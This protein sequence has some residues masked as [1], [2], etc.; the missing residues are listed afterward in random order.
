MTTD[1]TWQRVKTLF[2]QALE[3]PAAQRNAWLQHACDSQPELFA[4]VMALLDARERGPTLLQQD[5]MALLQ[6]V[7]PED[8]SDPDD[9]GTQLGVYRLV[10]LLGTGGM[11]RVYLAERA[12]GQ[13]QQRVALKLIRSE[14]VT[15]DLDKR[16]QR[17]RDT[18]ARLTHPNIAQLH[19]G[20]MDR[21]GAS[22]FTLEYV[23]GEPITDWCDTRHVDLRGRV[24]L[25]LKVCDAVAY[26][27]RNLVVHRDLKPSNIL[28]TPEG[29]PKLLD[30]GIAK[31]L[32]PASGNTALTDS[33]ARPMTREYAAPEQVLGEPV[34]T[35]TDVHALGV[36]MYR[37]LCGRMPYRH[38]ALGQIG[39]AKSILEEN[40]EAMERALERPF[41]TS[42]GA[43][44][45]LSAH[46]SGE[47]G[48]AQI[49]TARSTTPAGLRRALRGDL[50]RIVQRALAKAPDARYAT[51][52]ALA[53]DLNAWLQRRA[54]SGSTRR[55]RLRMFV[56]RHWL[57]LAAAA[58]LSGVLLASALLMAADARRIAR[59]AR[60]TLAVK[61]FLLDLF[62][63]AN[64]N[65]TGGKTMSLREVVDRGARRLS[66]IPPEQ[67]ALRAELGNTL[68]TIYFQ[69]GDYRKAA[70]LHDQ[71][72]R[73]V[74]DDP[75]NAL[76]AA[77]AER[78]ES[79]ELASLGDNKRAE[80][81]SDDALKRLQSIRPLPLS[82]M[83]WAL[84][85]A[86]WIAGKRFEHGKAA[87]LSRQALE[88]AGKPPVDPEL[89]MLALE[90]H[91]DSVRLAHH[92]EAALEDFR[93][94]RE[95]SLRLYGPD[96]QNTISVEQEYGTAL[97]DLSRYAQAET[98]LQAAFESSK[99]VFG[100]A[101]GRTLR[102][103]EMLG[104]NEISSGRIDAA[105]KRYARMLE[106]VMASVPRNEDV[107][108]EV[109]LNYAEILAY[110]DQGDP[111]EQ[112]LG[113]VRDYLQHQSGSEPAELAEV[114]CALGYVHLQAGKLET[115]ESEER[116]ALAL[117]ARAQVDGTSYE[118]ERLSRILLQ[119]GDVQAA[120]DY[121]RQAVDNAVKVDGEKSHSAARSHYS[122]A[123]ALA[124]AQ[125]SADAENE[126]RAALK[127]YAL[128]LPPA[129]MH[130]FSADPRLALG[131]L[132][133]K[134][135]TGHDEGVKLLQQAVS[136]RSDY[137]G[138]D[139]PRT[140]AA[141][142]MLEV[143]LAERR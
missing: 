60:T 47:A 39:W 7:A 100:E 97:S 111:A 11:G 112:L 50:E 136:L 106:V 6:R 115:A 116:Q 130:P 49:A 65:T 52:G 114:F 132:L 77:R 122:Y 117:L 81:L 62:H 61:N 19:D 125:R 45:M 41:P 118:L 138:V 18:L 143:A 91:A 54:I 134:R 83:G 89:M 70:E 27:H 71:A 92:Y 56:R 141:E 24:R 5:A 28:V 85:N 84:W 79:T 95:I 67:T 108:A 101:S 104:I 9:V 34:T 12:D 94:A 120:L 64:P 69:L 133:V 38:A 36:L 35:A 15:A 59:E 63:N 22:Y 96:E 55:Y 127:S 76:L 78:L 109:R 53:A 8:D 46:R 126:L 80:Q 88:L 57:P 51:A 98:H 23:P 1:S 102:V 58:V 2:G 42:P 26:A 105:R 44:S 140:R 75:A 110:V 121:G 21:Q 25:L 73:T 48:I 128:V 43:D 30:F 74:A 142:K 20:G 86:G 123:L 31:V 40:P 137:L 37:V 99:R 66:R 17:E 124:A 68:G 87:Q 113:Q 33:Q 13:F 82:D 107:L 90:Q 72:F 135:A 131:S 16:F 29:E 10:K 119:R 93:R 103:N 32:D 4:R 14:F 3:Q 139:A 129:G